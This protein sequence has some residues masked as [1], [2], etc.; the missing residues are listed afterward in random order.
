ME[1]FE[2][3][4]D[5]ICEGEKLKME[6]LQEDTRKEEIVFARQLIMF[7][8]KKMKIGS[9]SYIGAKFGK[10]HATVLHS[11]KTI[12]NYIDTD[13]LKRE[14]IISYAQKIGPTKEIFDLKIHM[15][16][17]MRPL[18]EAASDLEQRLINIQISIKNMM[19]DIDRIYKCN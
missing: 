6:Q 14:R 4:S 15:E 16:I 9:L 8:A 12:N 5:I 19:D 1:M 17:M 13:R 2:M 3:I 11:I 7:F 10:D 18:Q